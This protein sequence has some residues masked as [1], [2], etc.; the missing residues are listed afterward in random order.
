LLWT[1]CIALNE[2]LVAKFTDVIHC[3]R[4]TISVYRVLALKR[5]NL[6]CADSCTTLYEV[7]C[8]AWSR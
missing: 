7:H 4:N 6:I 2:V 8:H 3:I 5:K 1:V